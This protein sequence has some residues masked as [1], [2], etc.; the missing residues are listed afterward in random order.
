MV[1]AAMIRRPVEH[2]QEKWKPVFRP[3]MRP[4]PKEH[5]HMQEKLSPGFNGAAN[6]LCGLFDHR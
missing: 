4:M 3:K 5:F 2:F 6:A 1:G